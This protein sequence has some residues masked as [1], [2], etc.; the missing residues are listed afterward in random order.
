MFLSRNVPLVPTTMTMFYML[1]QLHKFSI[2]T[3]KS[4]ELLDGITQIEII[5]L[6]TI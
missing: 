4:Q 1:L 6:S 5:Q 2:L 3:T